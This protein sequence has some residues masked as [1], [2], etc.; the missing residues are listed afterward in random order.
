MDQEFEDFWRQYPRR[1][2]NPKKTALASYLRARKSASA[3]EILAGLERYQFDPNPRF[4]PMAATWLNQRRWECVEV[5]LAED[6]FGIGE[7][8][9][10]VPEPD[11]LSAHS[12]HREALEAVV[13]AAGWAVVWRGRLDALNA[14]LS[15][16]YVPESI[17]RVIGEAVKEF[18]RRGSL[19]AFDK[20][21]RF[22]AARIG[23]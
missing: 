1:P 8:L 11:G 18:G 17:G 22:R 12:Y 13:A 3:A 21:V 6:A 7:W 20:R 9:E 16:G 19:E 14:W 23:V 10:S 2:N 4:R 5:D 15:D